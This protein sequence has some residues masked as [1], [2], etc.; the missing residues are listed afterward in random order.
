MKKVVIALQ[1]GK[2]RHWAAALKRSQRS[3]MEKVV[4]VEHHGKGR[5]SAAEWKKSSNSRGS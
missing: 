2:S 4:I 1:R 3:S 5:H